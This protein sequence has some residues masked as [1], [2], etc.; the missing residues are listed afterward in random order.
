[1]AYRSAC[2]VPQDHGTEGCSASGQEDFREHHSA[3]PLRNHQWY[4]RKSSSLPIDN[5]QPEEYRMDEAE[6]MERLQRFPGTK[7]S[8]DDL[9]LSLATTAEALTDQT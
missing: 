2:G 8:L 3:A 6:V 1:M 9:Y 5:S 4:S 7:L